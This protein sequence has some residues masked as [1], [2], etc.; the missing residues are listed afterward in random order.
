LW[1]RGSREEDRRETDICI[2]VSTKKSH[3]C[4]ILNS[5]SKV[6]MLDGEEE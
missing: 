6:L 1:V 5:V 2:I 4:I 3:T